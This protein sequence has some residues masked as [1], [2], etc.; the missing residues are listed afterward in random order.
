MSQVAYFSNHHHLFIPGENQTAETLLLLHGTGGDEYSL[1][2]IGK[3]ISANANLLSVRGNVLEGSWNRYFKRYSDGSFDLADL[4]MRTKELAQ[5]IKDSQEKYQLKNLCAVG[6]S[7][8]ANVAVSLLS[9]FPQLIEKFILFRPAMSGEEIS[10]PNLSGSQVLIIS[11]SNDELVPTSTA[12]SLKN[13]LVRAGANVEFVLR[14]TGHQLDLED[15][16]IAKSWL[17]KPNF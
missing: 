10:F 2:E 5:F 7:N 14:N 16:E 11:G 17:I 13:Q 1:L 15:V 6:Y 4:E 3:A 9:A 8:G 12:E